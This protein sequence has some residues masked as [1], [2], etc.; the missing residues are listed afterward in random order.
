MDKWDRFLHNANLERF[1]KQLANTADEV[2]R[3]TLVDLLIA[4]EAKDKPLIADGT[5]GGADMAGP[6]TGLVQSKMTQGGH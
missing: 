2:Q 6:A 3:R 4:E 1:R 5:R